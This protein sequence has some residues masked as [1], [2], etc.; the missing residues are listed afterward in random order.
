M[1]LNRRQ[2]RL[3]EILLYDQYINGRHVRL[4]QELFDHLNVE[5]LG[6]LPDSDSNGEKMKERY[7]YRFD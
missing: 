4:A 2:V 7:G 1:D 5:G 6:N 3:L